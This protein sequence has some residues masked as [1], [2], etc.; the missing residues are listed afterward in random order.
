[1]ALESEL[2]GAHALGVR[3]HPRADRRPAADR[4]L[5]GRARAS[6]TSTRSGSSR[7]SPAST[8]A[9]TGRARPIGQPAGFT[10]ACALDPTAADAATEWDRLERKIAAGAHL[11]MTQ[12][13][14]DRG[15]GR[16][17]A[18]RGAAAVR[19]GRL[20]AAGAARAC[21]RSRARATPSSS[22]TRSP[23]SRSPTRRGPRC[24]TP[25]TAAPRS[26]WTEPRAPRGGHRRGLRDVHHAELRALRAVRRARPAAPEPRAREGDGL[27]RRSRGRHLRLRAAVCLAGDRRRRSSPRPCSCPPSRPPRPPPIRRRTASRVSRSTTTACSARRSSPRPSSSSTSWRS[28]TTST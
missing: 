1:M 27:M 6:G 23:A 11:V 28:S 18:R 15:P 16:G 10:I 19:A 5:P 13:L 26:G 7:S 3:E 4:R 12:P 21:C 14:Y 20:P 8:G 9:R 24:A 22:T 25:A 17:D 2:L